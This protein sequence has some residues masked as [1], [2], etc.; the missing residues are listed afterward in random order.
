VKAFSPEIHTQCA[1]FTCMLSV[2]AL[3]PVSTFM[4][5]M[6]IVSVLLLTFACP[7][8]LCS[9]QRFKNTINGPWDE[10]TVREMKTEN[11]Y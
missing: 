10:A 7:A 5:I 4:A 11:V 3:L 8:A 2:F 1:C 9:M 6:Y